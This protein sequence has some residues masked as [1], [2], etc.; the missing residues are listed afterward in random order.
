MGTDWGQI[1]T[2]IVA[3]QGGKPEAIHKL[4]EDRDPTQGSGKSMGLGA[5]QTCTCIQALHPLPRAP[6]SGPHLSE[7]VL[8][9]LQLSE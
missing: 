2:P 6:S 7:S 5:R 3:L 9:P 8:H 1:T 4:P